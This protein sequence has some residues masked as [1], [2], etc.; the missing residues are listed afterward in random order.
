MHK[1]KG[2][3]TPRS[4]CRG[5]DQ[6]AMIVPSPV[7]PVRP[8]KLSCLSCPSR[9]FR[10]FRSPRPSCLSVRSARLVRPSCPFC[11]LRLSCVRLSRL[12]VCPASVCPVRRV[13]D[14][15]VLS[16]FTFFRHS[17]LSVESLKPNCT[18]QTLQSGCGRSKLPRPSSGSVSR[19]FKLD[20]K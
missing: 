6:S 10:S 20:Q 5:L 1:P 17:S 15:P 2:T 7:R 14:S 4:A 8:S 16:R 13:S 3:V 9:P 11:S 19:L 18:C 12:Y